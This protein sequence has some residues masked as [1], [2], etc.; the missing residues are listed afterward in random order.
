MDIKIISRCVAYVALAGALMADA[1]ALNNRE[2]PMTQASSAAP[3]PGSR[4]SD[5]KLARCKTIGAE[6]ADDAVCKAVWKANR[7]RFFQSETHDPGRVT[8]VP[9]TSTLKASESRPEAE[10]PRRTPQSSST[11]DVGERR[12]LTDREGQL[13]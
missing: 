5:A 11:Y 6:A 10:L 13:Q 4:A 7:E 9:A 8:D 12:L 1:I 3:A 2:Y